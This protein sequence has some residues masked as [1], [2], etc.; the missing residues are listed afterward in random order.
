MALMCSESQQKASKALLASWVALR[1]GNY[2]QFVVLF[3]LKSAGALENNDGCACAECS[4]YCTYQGTTKIH[5][6]SKAEER[7]ATCVTW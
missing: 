2:E 3:Q 6:S 5:A 7:L 4:K 1:N